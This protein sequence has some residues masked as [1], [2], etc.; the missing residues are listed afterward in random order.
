MS[1]YE[2]GYEEGFKA[3]LEAMAAKLGVD[4]SQF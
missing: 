4:L 1:E 3:A 2:R